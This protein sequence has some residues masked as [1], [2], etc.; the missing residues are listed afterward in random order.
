MIA[1]VTFLIAR[2][3]KRDLDYIRE[4]LLKIEDGTKVFETIDDETAPH[5]GM[6][7]TGLSRQDGE[8]LVE[9]LGLIEDAGFVEMQRS[10][11]AIY[12]QRMTWVGHDFLDSVRDPEI[13]KKTKDGATAAGG[14][15]VELLRDLAKGLIKTQIKKHTGIDV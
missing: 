7:P 12:V 11:G 2:P 10:S 15:T 3:V 4:L 14:F 5:L 8:K 1:S 13:W 6:G 9:H